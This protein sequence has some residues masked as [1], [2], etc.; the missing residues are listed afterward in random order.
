MNSI[1]EI[2]TAIADLPEAEMRQLS[3]WLQSY[4]SDRWDQQ[5]AAD[6]SSGKLDRLLQK[7]NADIEANRIKPQRNPTHNNSRLG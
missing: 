7:V 6:A 1:T 2:K 5:M 4:V 3:D